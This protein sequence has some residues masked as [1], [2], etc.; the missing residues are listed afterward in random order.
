ME[1]TPPAS[2]HME[3]PLPLATQNFEEVPRRGLVGVLISLMPFARLLRVRE[4]QGGALTLVLHSVVGRSGNLV[5]A[6]RA[7]VARG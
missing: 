2:R 7:F 3:E 5:H 4:A 1:T 6:T